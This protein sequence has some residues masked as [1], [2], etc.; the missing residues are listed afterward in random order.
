M[1]EDP[2]AKYL[3]GQPKD[4][5]VDQKFR[6]ILRLLHKEFIAEYP[7]RV[8][9]R[10]AEYMVGSVYTMKNAPYGYCSM[11]NANSKDRERYFLIELRKDVSWDQMFHTILHEWAHALTWERESKDHGD[12]FA[13]ALGNLY[14][15]Y[16]ED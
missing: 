4:L 15:A 10:S 6:L 5:T 1:T 3:L 8:R 14:R 9:R 16:V 11:A 7:I 2:R 13:R 12:L